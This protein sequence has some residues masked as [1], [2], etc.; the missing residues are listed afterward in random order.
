MDNSN[1]APWLRLR[2]AVLFAAEPVCS[3]VAFLDP[4]L[5]PANH[6][7]NAVTSDPRRPHDHVLAALMTALALPHARKVTDKPPSNPGEVPFFRGS[8]G[9]PGNMEQWGFLRPQR[10]LV[11]TAAGRLA[12]R[13][14]GG[15][16]Q[17]HAPGHLLL[18]SA[19]PATGAGMN[20][21]DEWTRRAQTAARLR[22]TGLWKGAG[23]CAGDRPRL[24]GH[25][26]QHP[27]GAEQ[28]HETPGGRTNYA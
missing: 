6:L 12:F 5:A 16:F 20:P 28:H 2:G 8:S 4:A 24:D 17:S 21:S 22:R 27:R 18:S 3:A 13:E 11:A 23:C 15:E 7:R 25:S 26:Q 1:G 14:S 19:H 9:L 10:R